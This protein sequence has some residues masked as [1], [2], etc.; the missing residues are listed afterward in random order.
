MNTSSNR[1]KTSF[2]QSLSVLIPSL[3]YLRNR[4]LNK[5][6]NIIQSE[7]FIFLPDK[8]RVIE[9]L[10]TTYFGTL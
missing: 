4:I 10:K 9:S 6:D 2:V 8:L 3:R 1:I 7:D 5:N